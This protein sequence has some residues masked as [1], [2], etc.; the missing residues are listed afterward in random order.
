MQLSQCLTRYVGSIC[1][2]TRQITSVSTVQKQ[3][4]LQD[5]D[6]FL[7]QCVGISL[8]C[9]EDKSLWEKPYRISLV[10]RML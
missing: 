5:S 3:L 4:T 7:P 8:M 9:Q 10:M 2:T 1:P 6:V